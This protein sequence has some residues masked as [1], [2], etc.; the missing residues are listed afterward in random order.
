MQT[1]SMEDFD[2]FR[3]LFR[4][5]GEGI[6][7]V[8]TFPAFLDPVNFPMVDRRIAKWVNMHYIQFNATCPDAPQLMPFSSISTSPYTT[9]SM[10]DFPFYLRWIHW[11]RSMAEKL[12]KATGISWRARDVEMAVFTAWGGPRDPHP[13]MTLTPPP[14]N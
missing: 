14:F 5:Q 6:A 4:F 11:T 12:T 9:L 3:K 10:K 7:V 1:E 2:N 13:A 8:A